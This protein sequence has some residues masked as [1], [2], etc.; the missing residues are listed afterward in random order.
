MK[1]LIHFIHLC[2]FFNAAIAAAATA[3]GVWVS[4]AMAHSA[5][6]Y[7]FA[8]LCI[9]SFC[10]T[11]YGNCINDIADVEEDRINRPSRVLPSNALPVRIALICAICTALLTGIA[12]AFASILH[13]WGVIIPLLLLTLYTLRLKSIPLLGNVVVSLLVAY[14][15]LFGGFQGPEFFRLFIPA[16]LAF[17]LNLVRELIKDV[18][19]E[20]GDRRAGK[21]TSAVLNAFGIKTIIVACMIVFI[22]CSLV[23]Y[24]TGQYGHAYLYI[25]IALV[26]PLHLLISVIALAVRFPHGT[27]SLS[28]LVKLE[29]AAGL[30]AIA[31]DTLGAYGR[32]P[33]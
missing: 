9:A 2:R 16:T 23:A 17:I 29:L 31:M 26:Y 32:M 12:A 7:E 20:Y 27:G 4:G 15:L 19:D 33:F 24:T 22:P 14:A 3:L 10:A 8:L 21:R 28:L 18:Q 5:G 6:I 11:C 25:L 1:T 13:L 30:I